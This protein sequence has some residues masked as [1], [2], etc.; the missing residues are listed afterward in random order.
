MK[1]TREVK[2]G[3]LVRAMLREEGLETPLNEYRAQEA[4]GELMWPDIMRYTQRVH[5]RGGIRYLC[6]IHV[7]LR[8]ELMMQR[9]ALMHRINQHVGAQV[10]QQ[11]VI[12]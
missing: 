7:V 10:L 4:W 6:I 8:H 11:I 12:R 3:D 9:M 5:V 2:L 1:R